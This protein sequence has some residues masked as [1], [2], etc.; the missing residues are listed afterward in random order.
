MENCALSFKPNIS[1][2]LFCLEKNWLKKHP[3]SWLH[4]CFIWL[5]RI[6]RSFPKFQKC[7]HANISLKLK[8]QKVICVCEEGKFISVCGKLTFKQLLTIYLILWFYLHTKTKIFW[9]MSGWTKLHTQV[10]LKSKCCK[11]ISD[12]IHVFKTTITIL[13]KKP[14]V[15]ILPYLG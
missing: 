6:L 14:L 3:S 7:R 11:K 1:Y 15:L 2:W 13:E 9:D 4:L 8:K 12:N 5:T 10:R